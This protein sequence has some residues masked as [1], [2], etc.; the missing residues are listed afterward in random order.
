M[1][2]YDN[3]WNV[4]EAETVDG[5]FS[6]QPCKVT[7]NGEVYYMPEHYAGIAHALLMIVDAI[8]DK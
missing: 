1:K 7:I 6:P 5:G 3:E 4:E 2:K 8:N